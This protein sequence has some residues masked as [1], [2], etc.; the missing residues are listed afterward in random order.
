VSPA[1]STIPL[2]TLCALLKLGVLN[3]AG[4]SVADFAATL[5]SPAPN[6]INIAKRQEQRRTFL[7]WGVSMSVPPKDSGRRLAYGIKLADPLTSNLQSRSRTNRELR[8]EV[9]G[10][11]ISK[12]SRAKI[13][14]SHSEQKI[15]VKHKMELMEQ[16]GKCETGKRGNQT[17]FSDD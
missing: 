7:Q 9:G 12:L 10:L 17:Q 14:Y 4:A 2:L 11:F 8:P 1:G 13:I 3:P 15:Y 16:P 6:A 5:T